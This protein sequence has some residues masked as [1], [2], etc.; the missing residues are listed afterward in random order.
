MLTFI[1]TRRSIRTNT[2][3]SQVRI[4]PTPIR[5]PIN[6]LVIATIFQPEKH[7]A[8]LKFYTART[9]SHTVSLLITNRVSKQPADRHQPLFGWIT[10][11]YVL[12]SSMTSR[13]QNMA[14]PFSHI[15]LSKF[16]RTSIEIFWSLLPCS[17]SCDTNW[18]PFCTDG[19]N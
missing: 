4:L 14:S 9:C 18:L 8:L 11:D 2:A 13:Y 16:A 7:P 6:N 5:C 10:N 3:G 19:W 15:V 12:R 17:P 1:V